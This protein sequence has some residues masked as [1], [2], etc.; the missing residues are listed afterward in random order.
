[1]TARARARLSSF[2][3][4]CGGDGELSAGSVRV[5]LLLDG[6]GCSFD[7]DASELSRLSII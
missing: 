6:P 1:M 3:L 5:C 2:F 4:F 7:D